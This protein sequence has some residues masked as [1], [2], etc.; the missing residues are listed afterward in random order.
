MLIVFLIASAPI[1]NAS[2]PS[3]IYSDYQH[4]KLVL[5]ITSNLKI[6]QISKPKTLETTS[7]NQS[8]SSRRN[9]IISMLLLTDSLVF[10]GTDSG[11][12]SLWN[13]LTDQQLGIVSLFPSLEIKALCLF[14]YMGYN[15]DK[16]DFEKKKESNSLGKKGVLLNSGNGKGEKWVLDVYFYEN[17]EKRELKKTSKKIFLKKKIKLNFKKKKKK[18]KF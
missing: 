15:E 12:L 3:Y 16:L 6:S 10:L 9:N 18:K 17:W 4:K 2:L 13:I 7:D 14:D 1:K 8:M 5:P 11:K